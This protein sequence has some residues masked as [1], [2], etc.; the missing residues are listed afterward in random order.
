[1]ASN[2]V[3]IIYALIDKVSPKAKQVSA[4]LGGIDEKAAKA[5]SSVDS[6]E[7]KQSKLSGSMVEFV[8]VS[9]GIVYGLKKIGESVIGAA[10]KYEQQE[11]AFTSMLGSSLRAQELI[12]E[13]QQTA[14]S[15]PF[16]QTDLIDYAK[17]L[18]A[19]GVASDEVIPAMKM[20]GDVAS[21]LGTEKLPQIVRGYSDIQAAGRAMGGDLK[22]LRDAAVPIERYLS[23][24]L[25]VTQTQVR[26]LG[27]ES[28]ISAEDVKKAFQLMTSEGEKFHG[29][30]AAQSKTTGGALSNLRD[31]LGILAISFGAPLLAPLNFLIG[32]LNS[33]LGLI[34]KL[35]PETKT[36]ISVSVAVAA[37][38]MGLVTA[39]GLLAIAIGGAKLA[40][41]ALASSTGIGLVVAAVGLLGVAV[42]KNLNSVRIYFYEANLAIVQVIISIINHINSLLSLLEKIPGN[43][44]L[45]IGTT[46]LK[47]SQAAYSKGLAEIK[48]AMAKSAKEEKDAADKKQADAAASRAKELADKKMALENAK[49]DK[50]RIEKEA[51]DKALD[52]AKEE[53]DKAKEILLQQKDDELEIRRKAIAA[54][55]LM[56]HVV[57][58]QETAF[59]Q[60]QAD[61]H[62]EINARLAADTIA[63]AQADFA[64]QNELDNLSIEDKI[65]RAEEE[66][67]RENLSSESKNAISQ[68]L[69]DLELE[70]MR[71]LDEKKKLQN[72][73]F[74]ESFAKFGQGQLSLQEAINNGMLDFYKQQAYAALDIEAAKLF[75]TGMGLL[76]S[77]MFTNPMGY[78][79]LAGA[80]LVSAGGRAAIGSIKL[81][82]GGI[83]MPQSGGVQ[84]TIGEGGRAEAV[85]P[86]DDPRSQEVLGGGG[87]SSRVIILDAD[88]MTT[89]AK[90]VYKKQTEML[91]TG[92][93]TPRK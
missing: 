23:Q 17:K 70:R 19:V 18:I 10:I 81:A 36:F 8:A 74:L 69:Y 25:G 62:R 38:V 63:L 51:S 73:M 91:R 86:L 29:M 45:S 89:L 16:E 79:H 65:L 2:I 57:G 40:L 5:G 31:Q 88:G 39:F 14:A 80:A 77:S 68:G 22:Q 71:K 85:I 82:E 59:A 26:K 52:A 78:A 50:L 27:E 6:L 46:G 66:L 87:N 76:I 55:L 33:F 35:S 64:R 4:A 9:A 41:I 34:R 92:E 49:N 20:L 7:K 75:Q 30:M 54:Q 48:A 83:V 53:S 43:L 61:K 21:A 56:Q 42:Y 44:K 72:A 32:A 84:A 60:S 24:V 15:T 13:I 11:M 1:V 12:A 93:L 47:E 58:E 67:S 28:K 90:G 37:G 3:E